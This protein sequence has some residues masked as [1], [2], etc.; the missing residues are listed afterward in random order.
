MTLVEILVAIAIFLVMSTVMIG[1]LAAATGLYRQGERA[2]TANDE[3]MAVLNVLDRDLGRAIPRRQGGHFWAWHETPAAGVAD[4]DCIAAWIIED[5]ASLQSGYSMVAW[6]V[7]GTAPAATLRR[8]VFRDVVP[9]RLETY[10]A[11]ADLQKLAGPGSVSQDLVGGVLHFGVWLLGTSRGGGALPGTG[12]PWLHPADDFW[13]E[14]AGIPTP[15]TCPT[16]P[17]A[18]QPP[19][20][21]FNR[22]HRYPLLARFTLIL[23]GGGRTLPDGRVLA[24]DQERQLRTGGL[25]D[26]PVLP[27]SLARIGDELIGLHGLAGGRLLVNEDLAHGPLNRPGAID[28][29]G[30]GVYRS[31]PPPSGGHPRGTAVFLGHQFSLIRQLPGDALE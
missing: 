26:V 4:G 19:Y 11:D 22:D 31:A 14:A 5:P 2:R 10:P 8:T 28:G 29:L 17:I 20:S 15:P 27:G 7:I 16:E 12:G 1:I 13:I 30:R 21:T 25:G 9:L 23:T 24:D 3:T 18:G 6:G